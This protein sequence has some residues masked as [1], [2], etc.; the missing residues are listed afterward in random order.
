MYW[1][2]TADVLALRLPRT[3]QLRCDSSHL[4]ILEEIA[5]VRL[6][7]PLIWVVA[8]LST[9]GIGV[10]HVGQQE[11]GKVAAELF[12]RSLLFGPTSMVNEWRQRNVRVR[13]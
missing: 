12:R 4:L 1:G 9:C 11:R 6:S 5:V 3:S 10:C 8:K 7:S 2:A 13:Q